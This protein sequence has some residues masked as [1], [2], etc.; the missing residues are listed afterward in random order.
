MR[1]NNEVVINIPTALTADW[2]SRAINLAHIAQYSLQASED[3]VN[4]FD[5]GTALT[6]VASSTVQLTVPNFSAKFIRAR[7]STI[8]ATVVTGYTLLKA[9]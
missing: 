5:V 4:W 6:A 8:G 1:I 7:V 2:Q 3:N 9:F